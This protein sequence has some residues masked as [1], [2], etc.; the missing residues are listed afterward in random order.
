GDAAPSPEEAVLGSDERERLLAAVNRMRESDR[1][2]IAYR[3]FLDLSERETAEALGVR[4]G[5]VKS[6][7]SR[8]LGRLRTLLAEGAPAG[9]VGTGG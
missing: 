7:L 3:F 8:A 5:T 6:R 9:E 1:M 2:V 4:P